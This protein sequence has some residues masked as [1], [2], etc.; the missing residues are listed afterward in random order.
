[1]WHNHAKISHNTSQV[2]VMTV[3]QLHVNGQQQDWYLRQQINLQ[4]LKVKK[5]P[6]SLL[7]DYTTDTLKLDR[8]CSVV[9]GLWKWNSNQQF[10]KQVTFVRNKRTWL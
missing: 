4:S 6:F 8:V 7:S 3:K 9:D 2:K 5:Q 10:L 1:M